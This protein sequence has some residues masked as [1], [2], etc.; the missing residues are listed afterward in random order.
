MFC[1]RQEAQLCAVTQADGVAG[2]RDAEILLGDVHDVGAEHLGLCFR[3]RKEYLRVA[4]HD[5][6]FKRFIRKYRRTDGGFQD[7]PDLLAD[8]L[9]Q[10]LLVREKVLICPA[11]KSSCV[12]PEISFFLYLRFCA[13]HPRH[14]PAL[15][16]VSFPGFLPASLYAC[17]SAPAIWWRERSACPFPLIP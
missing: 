2:Q 7:V 9:A 1:G 17:C 11:S 8:I 6:I 3:R 14:C 5:R 15:R 4:G 10:V 13:V 12:S 16:R